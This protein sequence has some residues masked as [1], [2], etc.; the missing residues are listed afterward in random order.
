MQNEKYIDALNSFYKLKEKYEDKYNKDKLKII[1]NPVY[2]LQEKQEKFKQ[3]KKYCINCRKEGGS[4]FTN[5][6]NKLKVI[7][8]HI[9]QPCKLNIELDKGLY[10]NSE[11]L[12]D[13]LNEIINEK[14][15]ELIK[16]KLD[17]LFGYI[18]EDDALMKFNHLKEEIQKKNENYRRVEVFYLNIVDNK[19]KKDLLEEAEINLHLNIQQIKDLHKVYNINENKLLLKNVVEKYINEILPL[20][21]SISE[22]EYV[23]RTID[24]IEDE[25]I[26]VEKAYTINELEYPIKESKIISNKK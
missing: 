18:S 26:L 7:C 15:T 10:K 21:S 13:Y 17:F 23:Y 8:G 20:V 12:A 1:N 6:N 14:K 25:N 11:D 22:L 24:K 3:L 19:Y 9:Q 16:I 2:S 4:I 5:E